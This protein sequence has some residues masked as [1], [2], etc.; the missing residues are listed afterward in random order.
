[1]NNIFNNMLSKIDDILLYDD[2]LNI[3]AILDKK[4]Q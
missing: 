2:L 3:Y 4:R 1:M